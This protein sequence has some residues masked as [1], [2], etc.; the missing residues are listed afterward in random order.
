MFIKLAEEKKKDDMSIQEKIT[1][2]ED[3]TVSLGQNYLEVPEEQASRG[4]W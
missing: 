4:G 3:D 1:E 2:A